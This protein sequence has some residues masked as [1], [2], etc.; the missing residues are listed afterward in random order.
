MASRL[1]DVNSYKTNDNK[2][3]KL[4]LTMTGIVLSDEKRFNID[5]KQVINKNSSSEE[6]VKAISRA[7]N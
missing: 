7:F 2:S 1:E 3:Q 6:L 4:I 5:I